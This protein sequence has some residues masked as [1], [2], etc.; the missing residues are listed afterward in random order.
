MLNKDTAGTDR[1]DYAKAMDVA[2]QDTHDK[3]AFF[4]SQLVARYGPAR[5]AK[6]ACV[7]KSDSPGTC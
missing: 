7:V 2:A 6:M 4:E 1:G 3:W 5:G